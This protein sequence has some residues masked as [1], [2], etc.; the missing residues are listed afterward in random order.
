MPS[1]AGRGKS[2]ERQ[3]AILDAALALFVERGFYGTA[4]PA[5]AKRA[6]V[7]TGSIYNYF[8]SKEALVN[9]L[10]R[11]HKQAIVSHVVTHFPA[12]AEPYEQFHAMWAYMAEFALANPSAF[13]FLELYQHAPY[14]DDESR[15][16]EHQLRELGAGFL[17]RAQG[18]GMLKPMDPILMM[19][20]VFGAFTGMMRAQW[21]GRLAL[22]PEALAQAEAACWDAIALR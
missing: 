11:R 4:V 19:E 20:L 12:L 6:G 14:L 9:V 13:A 2:L 21:E 17:L 15:A 8:D 10:F 18:L 16:L 3:D 5:I 7:S 1:E 22:T